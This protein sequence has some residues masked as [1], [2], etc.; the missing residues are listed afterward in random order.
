[1]SG[2][3]FDDFLAQQLQRNSS[4]IEDGDFTAGVMA[5]LPARQRLN[6]WLER[7]I[8]AVPVTLIA[9]LVASQLPW[10]DLVRPAYGWWLTSSGTSVMAVLLGLMLLAVTL[11]LLWV[12]RRSSAL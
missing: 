6:P 10:R 7:L 3:S 1:M 11:P 8:M 4:Y 5:S 12:L 9:L 2:K